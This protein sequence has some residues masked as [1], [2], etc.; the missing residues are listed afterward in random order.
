[1]EGPCRGDFLVADTAR[2]KPG[3]V[4]RDYQRHQRVPCRHHANRQ[5]LTDGTSNIDAD[6]DGQEWHREPGLC[7][8]IGGFTP[9]A[10]LI[11]PWRILVANSGRFGG[12]AAIDAVKT[13]S[14]SN[15]DRI[16]RPEAVGA[17]YR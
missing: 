10:S 17:E 8:G 16:L 3:E 5:L 2:Y 4:L 1:M 14:K 12:S 7:V 15:G 11:Y 13:F 6:V 9:R